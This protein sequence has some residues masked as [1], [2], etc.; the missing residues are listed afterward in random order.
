MTL[1]FLNSLLLLPECS[2]SLFL[3]FPL[4]FLRICIIY[5]HLYI[6]KYF[7]LFTLLG[8]SAV[9]LFFFFF[10]FSSFFPDSVIIAKIN[11]CSL[12]IKQQVSAQ[13]EA[14]A[15]SY[16][17]MEATCEN[18]MNIDNQMAVA[19]RQD[20]LCKDNG[21]LKT[22]R[23]ALVAC[24]A[25]LDKLSAT[26]SAELKQA[27]F[28]VNGMY[29]LCPQGGNDKGCFAELASYSTD[30]QGL[31]L[32]STT[33][34]QEKVD[35]VCGNACIRRVEAF[36]LST[37]AQAAPD[38]QMLAEAVVKAREIICTKGPEGK[39]CFPEFNTMLASNS[40]TDPL[41]LCVKP[42][43]R[44]AFT[45]LIETFGSLG[46][47]TAK[48]QIAG[49]KALLKFMCLK[50]G[51]KYCWKI[52]ESLGEGDDSCEGA[53]ETSC[54][55]G[56]KA[57]AETNF[58]KLGCCIPALDD[59][60][61]KVADN[62]DLASMGQ[63]VDMMKGID[64]ACETKFDFTQ[65][66]CSLAGRV[67]GGV[68]I[69]GITKAIVDANKDKYYTSVCSD[70]SDNSGVAK[71]ECT[72]TGH[73]SVEA[74]ASA[75]T[76]RAL[77]ATAGVKFD[78]ELAVEDETTAKQIKAEFD[79]EVSGG[80]LEL[81]AVEAE[82]ARTSP[83]SEVTVDKTKSTASTTVVPTPTPSTGGSSSSTSL[84]FSAVLVLS[85]ILA[86]AL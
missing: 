29:K 36:Y 34:T 12:A 22:L 19:Q 44:K 76:L 85:A 58:N 3:P 66:G 64:K 45:A 74:E 9:F 30:L 62:K 38:N 41:V 26:T 15:K 78:F 80:T 84:G 70:L 56:C 71:D 35:A 49:F 55:S 69:K 48:S 10:F 7:F 27:A 21:C 32:G 37:I 52:M 24:R 28:I 54:P 39:F 6:K 68:A 17:D 23:S 79:S 16:T 47:D 82:A 33:V 57:L 50:N 14:A 59:F 2:L 46:G 11:I 42:C 25:D 60:A 20:A 1:F 51:D 13:C 67:K 73:A 31:T 18:A 81:P 8:F 63:A 53:S 86:A 4:V 5:Q 43:I 83:G 65:S 75:G 40:F 77:Q 61:K 72:I